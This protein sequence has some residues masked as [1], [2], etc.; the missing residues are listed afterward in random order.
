M[1]ARSI[2]LAFVLLPAVAGAQETPQPKPID[3]NL[4]ASPDPLTQRVISAQLADRRSGGVVSAVLLSPASETSLQKVTVQGSA[5][6]KEGLALPRSAMTA[7]FTAPRAGF[8]EADLRDSVAS[9]NTGRV[10]AAPARFA[11]RSLATAQ[12]ISV[13]EQMN[14]S[15][16]KSAA[17]KAWDKSA[18]KTPR[19]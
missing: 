11:K 10:P 12:L 3:V 4:Y 18:P 15:A 13:V 16:E 2:L 6:S 17:D 9:T 7:A 1:V 5:T 14:R 8:V 19:S